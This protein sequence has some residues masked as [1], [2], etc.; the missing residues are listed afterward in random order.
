MKLNFTSYRQ[1]PR[2]QFVNTPHKPQINSESQIQQQ[3]QQQRQYT[4][5]SN[6]IGRIQNGGKCLACNK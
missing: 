5:N 3:Q 2:D 1:I 4:Y 6:M